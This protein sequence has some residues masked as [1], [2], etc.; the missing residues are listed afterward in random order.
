MENALHEIDDSNSA[1]NEMF[2]KLAAELA[3]NGIV[4]INFKGVIVFC[5][6]AAKR[7]SGID[8]DEPVMGRSGEQV[9]PDL[10]P[11]MQEVLRSGLPQI[12]R[13]LKI[14]GLTLIT[15]HSPVLSNGMICGVVSVFLDNWSCSVNQMV[16][17]LEEII[18]SSDDG[19]YIVDRQGITLRANLSFEKV[20][21]IKSS[22]L[23]GLVGR[24]LSDLIREGY[25]SKSVILLVSQFGKAITINARTKHGK[26]LLLSGNPV[27]DLAGRVSMVIT[28]VCDI[29]DPHGGN[30]Q[31]CKSKQIVEKHQTKLEQINIRQEDGL[32][33]V[34]RS[35][36]MADVLELG[37]RIA[38]V[39]SSVLIYGETGVGKE[40]VAR[41]IH[42]RS[43]RAKNGEIIKINCGAIPEHLLESELFGYEKGAFT[44][45]NQTGK[46]GLFELAD[47]GTLF[48]DEIQTLS[49]N[50][51][52]K[53]L[54]VVQDRQII[55]LGGTA[56]K[57]I[58]TR[59]IAA[60]NRDLHEMVRNG[61]FRE[62][63]FFRLNVVPIHVPP[64]RQR[65]DDILPL[66]VHFLGKYNGKYGR[67]KSFSSP[68]IDH[69]MRYPW[70]GNVRELSNV[71]ERLVVISKADVI[72]PDDLPLEV[73]AGNM[74][75]GAESHPD[76]LCGS[77]L[78]DAVEK[79][80]HRLIEDAIRRYGTA[81][82]AAVH[83][84][85]DPATICRK[86]QRYRLNS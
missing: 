56:S 78:K 62:D 67:T 31:L 43:G 8:D 68:A 39:E 20:T 26:E 29:T 22:E 49:L 76:S 37:L 50:L 64:L 10:W 70:P 66:V 11:H 38:P 30:R 19:L 55:R 2:Y 1:Q 80:E 40:I 83:L 65:K 3:Y 61:T 57:K 6:S 48:L 9:L 4:A 12:H 13:E 35:E 53:L 82:K 28:E 15:S 23:I 5:N 34:V 47:H 81:Q 21:G 46:K 85:V 7:I 84:K 45:A 86:V 27:L 25:I 54:C 79:F 63:L 77:S 44:G 17:Q 52:A 71:I 41:F 32:E 51:Q 18:E 73:K 33:L 16:S 75:A 69:L 60:S 14:R 58:D 74:D 72:I 59:I 24:N 42:R 36:A